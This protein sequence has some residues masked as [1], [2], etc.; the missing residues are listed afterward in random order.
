MKKPIYLLITLFI[1]L[2]SCKTSND[3]VSKN[4]LTK[5]KYLKGYHF[6][7]QHFAK[8]KFSGTLKN[9][10]QKV[11]KNQ[12][13][14][15]ESNDL[16]ASINEIN[17]DYSNNILKENYLKEIKT[18][19]NTSN[20]SNTTVTT[21]KFLNK[22]K[23]E[24]ELILKNNLEPNKAL[25]KTSQKG[26]TAALLSLIFGTVGFATM[27]IVPGIG[28]LFLL[29]GLILGFVGLKSEEKRNLALIGLIFSGI[30]ILIFLALITLVVALLL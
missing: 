7:G 20:T 27:W 8:N 9:E 22:E 4:N 18:S 30:G 29:S 11:S 6:S 25:N 19:S 21:N 14:P 23:K 26:D 3:V 13:N 16:V 24:I 28:I 17:T 2:S 5:R 1:F 12:L 15:L 10:Q